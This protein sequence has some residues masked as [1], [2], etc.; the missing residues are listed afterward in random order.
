M[1][2]MVTGWMGSA[3]GDTSVLNRSVMAGDV[4]GDGFDD[5]IVGAQDADPNGDYP[6]PVT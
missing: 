4:N 2:A 5:V 3:A 6:A 1:A